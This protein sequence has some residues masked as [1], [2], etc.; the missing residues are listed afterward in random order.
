[1]TPSVR[2]RIFIA[3]HGRCYLC[4]Q[5][6]MDD[7]WHVEHVTARGLGG[8]D[9]EDNVRIAHRD[10]HKPKTEWDVRRMRK[11][12]RCAK[13]AAGIKRKGRPLPGTKASGWKHRINGD[14]ERRT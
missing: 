6:V 11:A 8:G 3:N 7:D 1:M 12:D 2:A 9:D 5:K 13:A 14:W 10:C 4:S